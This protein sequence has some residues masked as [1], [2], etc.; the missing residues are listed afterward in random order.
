MTKATQYNIGAIEL[1]PG[2]W[3]G[4]FNRMDGK[5]F[6]I[7]GTTMS[8]FTTMDYPT[9]EAALSGAGAYIEKHL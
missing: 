6:T 3:C 1:E 8:S 5:P 2:K 7:Q 9:K 4:H